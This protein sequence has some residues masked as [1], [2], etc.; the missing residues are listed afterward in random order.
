MKPLL[1]YCF[2]ML[3]FFLVWGMV[4]GV[5]IEEMWRIEIWLQGK[6]QKPGQAIVDNLSVHVFLFRRI[7]LFTLIIL[8]LFICLFNV[9]IRCTL[10]LQI[11]IPAVNWVC[12][13]SNRSPWFKFCDKSLCGICLA[14]CSCRL[15]LFQPC[16]FSC[17]SSGVLSTSHLKQLF[18]IIALLIS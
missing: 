11:C 9:L 10:T 12:W 2:F 14:Y 4:G 13:S 6:L 8:T 15:E 16:W 3:F 18:D 1:K 5:G 7:C 17:K